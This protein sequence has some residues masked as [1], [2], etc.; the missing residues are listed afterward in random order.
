MI[1]SDG[2]AGEFPWI[3]AEQR[4]DQGSYAY[5]RRRQRDCCQRYPGIG[6]GLRMLEL[7]MVPDETSVPSGVFGNVRE[8]REKARIAV[9]AGGWKSIAKR[10]ALPAAC[11]PIIENV[12]ARA[13][14]KFSSTSLSTRPS[15]TAGRNSASRRCASYHSRFADRCSHA[16]V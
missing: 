11:V 6:D 4:R 10:I 16:I 5:S 3:S 15:G 14:H 1:E 13:H 12:A 9:L 8:F 7:Y 2:L